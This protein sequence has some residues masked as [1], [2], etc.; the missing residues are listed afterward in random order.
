MSRHLRRF[1][2]YR[3][4]T[5][6]LVVLVAG[7]GPRTGA[8]AGR[9]TYQG[10]PVIFGSVQFTGSDNQPRLAAIDPEGRFSLEAVLAGENRVLVHS[11]DPRRAV[12]RDKRDQPLEAP[13]VDPKLWF[14]VPEKYSNPQKS[15]L[16][17]TI[18]PGTSNT[19][20]IDLK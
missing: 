4:V 16:A 5:C 11:P 9:V 3:A 6:L 20:D 18:Q 8:V 1:G 15:D 19:F 13:P 14:P 17:F 10:K 2:K 7:C 12:R